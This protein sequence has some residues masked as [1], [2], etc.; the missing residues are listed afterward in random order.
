M[1]GC[2]QQSKILNSIG[3]Y[4]LS[5]TKNKRENQMR[6]STV[7]TYDM[8]MNPL[9]QALHQL[10]GSG[11]IQEIYN[12]VADILQLTDEQLDILHYPE[13][14]STTAV[15][16]RLAWTRTYLK[17]YGI[18]ENSKRGVWAFTSEGSKVEQ[19]ESKE[20]VQFV[21]E[22]EKKQKEAQTDEVDEIE[23]IE[24]M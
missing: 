5:N 8:M 20:V 7:P 9:I 23:D 14:S 22:Q 19:V 13:K 4:F 11:T 21:R 24:E 10:G 18:I 3:K 1:I 16:Y 15:G 12:E 17:K 2:K 6:N